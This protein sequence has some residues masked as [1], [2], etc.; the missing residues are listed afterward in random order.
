MNE[1]ILIV[2]DEESLRE[3]LAYNLN[4]QGYS[5][6]TADNGKTALTLAHSE[7]PDLILLD[8]MLPGL[9]GIEV[10][11][12]LRQTK[13]TPI[14]MLTARDEVIDRVVGLEV[15]ADDYLTKP[16]SM[17]ELH[18]RIKAMLRRAQIIKAQYQPAPDIVE[19]DKLIMFSDV[20]INLSHHEV[21]VGGKTVELKPKEYDLL[22]YLASHL[23]QVISREKILQEV[24]G[25]DY[26][27]DSRT[28]DVHVRWLREKIE[29]DPHEP[30]HLITVRGTGYRLKLKY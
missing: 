26:F 7:N 1:K 5:V 24:W 19:Q 8:V 14:I 12:Q 10:C 6:T 25:W 2:E 29:T 16:F 15:G 4:K 28:V 11:R 27:G 9:D 30:V 17:H 3:A 18:A 23:D 21:T 20:V 13:S 22:V